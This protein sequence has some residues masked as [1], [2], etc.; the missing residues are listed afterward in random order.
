MSNTSTNNLSRKNLQQLLAA[1]GSRPTEDTT[2]IE[3]TEYDWHQPRHFNSTELKRLDDFTKE[4]AAILAKKFTDLCHSNFDVTIAST[5]QHFANEFLR[6]ISE[7]KKGDYYLA[8]GPDQNHLCGVVSIPS[9]TATLLVT[10]LLGDSE[11][12]EGPDKTLS[13]LEES[14]LFDIGTTFVG[15]LSGCYNDYDFQAVGSIVKD[16]LPLELQ[17]TEEFCRITFNIKTADSENSCEAQ[18]LIFCETLDPIAGKSAQITGG[19][20]TE[21]ISNA[22]VDRL[23]EMP[24][25]VTAQLGSA[26][27]TL[28]EAISLRPCDILLLDKGIDEPVELI[29]EG[30]TLFQGRAAKSAGKYAV[31]ITKLCDT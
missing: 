2:Q 16:R 27:L 24:V 18:L 4:T 30:R 23:Q 22:I 28:E 17:G 1:V 6:Q 11:S 29:V 26:M 8:F 3:A 20:S 5:T 21:D 7:N 14:L 19:F 15:T 13:Q 10:E 9:Q 25:S 31:V 12:Q